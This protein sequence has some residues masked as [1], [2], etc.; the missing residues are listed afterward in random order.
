MLVCHESPSPTLPQNS[1]RLKPNPN[2]TFKFWNK[3]LLSGIFP[4]V[5]ILCYFALLIAIFFS[6]GNT[7]TFLWGKIPLPTQSMLFRWWLFR[8]LFHAD[9]MA[10]HDW[11]CPPGLTRGQYPLATVIA[12]ETGTKPYFAGAI[13]KEVLSF[14]LWE[15]G[16]ACRISPG[17]SLARLPTPGES[18]SGNKTKA[19]K[20]SVGDGEAWIPGDVIHTLLAHSYQNY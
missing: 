5:M 14:P 15:E 6:S 4:V 1:I 9:P 16:W 10:T 8:W 7:S 12:S 19:E 20:N 17:A 11:A 3:L 13:Q 18:M 2:T